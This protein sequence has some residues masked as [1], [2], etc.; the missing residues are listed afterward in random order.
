MDANATRMDTYLILR[1]D[2]ATR[3]RFKVAAA[4]QGVSMSEVLRAT[5]AAVCPDPGEP[6]EA[7]GGGDD[8]RDE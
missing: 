8:E 1:V 2:K 6:P 4:A 3:D 7:E 5:I